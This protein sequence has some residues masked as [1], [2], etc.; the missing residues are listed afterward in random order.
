MKVWGKYE[1]VSS[2]RDA[3]I[4]LAASFVTPFEP[5][6]VT[7]GNGPTIFRPQLQLVIIDPK[8]N[9]TLWWLAQDIQSAFR[10][11]TAEKNFDEAVGGLINQLKKLV[12]NS[13]SAA[14]VTKQ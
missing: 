12:D 11:K 4:V 7:G 3:D 10:E 1:L 13:N 5:L 14:P 2:P 8:T 6:S 9:V